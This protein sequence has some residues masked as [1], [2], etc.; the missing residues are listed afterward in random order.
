[1]HSHACPCHN[2]GLRQNAESD[3]TFIIS[4]WTV[5]AAFKETSHFSLSCQLLQ[6]KEDKVSSVESSHFFCQSSRD[7]LL[8]M[9]IAPN[10]FRPRVYLWR[11]HTF[12]SSYLRGQRM[13]FTNGPRIDFNLFYKGEN[14]ANQP[15]MTLT[16]RNQLNRLQLTE[17]NRTNQKQLKPFGTN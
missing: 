3:K 12:I 4:L 17:T 9:A 13:C 11:L 15:K 2:L 1:M 16:D 6:T 10:I 5:T 8:H 14:N 7:F